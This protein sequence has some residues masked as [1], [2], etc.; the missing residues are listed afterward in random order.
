MVKGPRRRGFTLVELLVVIAIIGILI[1]MLVPAV[2]VV[3]GTAQKTACMSNMRQLGLGVQNFQNTYGRYPPSCLYGLGPSGNQPYESWSWLALMLPFLDQKPLFDTLTIRPRGLPWIEPNTS[4]EYHKTARETTIQVFLCP[5]SKAGRDYTGNVLKGWLGRS[6]SGSIKG[7]LTS[8][9]GMGDTQKEGIPFRL[10]GHGQT[11]PYPSTHPDGVMYPDVEGVRL[12]DITDSQSQTIL[13]VET[14]ENKYSR[15]MFGTEATLAG[16]PSQ[17]DPAKAGTQ[18]V[19]N[20][21][22][23][24]YAPQG[25]D[26]G[27]KNDSKLQ[28]SLKT[29]LNY[30]YNPTANKYDPKEDIKYGPSSS[31]AGMVNHLFCD[32]NVRAIDVNVDV[33]A[34]MFLITRGGNEQFGAL[35]EDLFKGAQ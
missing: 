10:P 35:A 14:I 27:F 21:R 22:L 23:G 30:D 33:A 25:F 2:N 24:Y 6:S 20:T 16:L 12:S 4:R 18:I 17:N 26:G 34:Y 3:R 28:A 11:A 5:S 1:G 29:Y 7:A 31:H 32:G 13:A 19:Y 8:Y 9:K 15:W